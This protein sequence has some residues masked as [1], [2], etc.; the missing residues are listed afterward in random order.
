MND[1]TKCGAHGCTHEP[2]NVFDIV[3]ED[4][5]EGCEDLDTEVAYCRKHGYQALINS[6]IAVREGET[7]SYK[8]LRKAEEVPA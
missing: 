4:L 2:T 8:W 1:L 5:P 3:I 6:A 7:P